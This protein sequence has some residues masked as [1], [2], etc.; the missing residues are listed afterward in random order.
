MPPTLV[1]DRPRRP[2]SRRPGRTVRSR[3]VRTRRTQG[4]PV[5]FVGALVGCL[6][7]GLL[8]LLAVNTAVAQDAFRL[9]GL[10]QE[11]RRTAE[12]LESVQRDVE[13]LRA[14]T[15]LA[16]RAAALGMRPA[17]APAFLPLPTGLPATSDEPL[18][19]AASGTAA[20]SATGERR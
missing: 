3:S 19:R 4:P 1:R 10:R 11:Q 9:D 14:P 17:G 7:F 12:R 16:A 8:G 18:R 20:P 15:A 5:A 6:A 2:G 13:S